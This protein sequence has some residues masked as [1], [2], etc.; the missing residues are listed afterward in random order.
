MYR[1]LSS[2]QQEAQ[3]PAKGKQHTYIN[4][5]S[6]TSKLTSQEAVRVEEHTHTQIKSK[7][8]LSRSQQ[9]AQAPAKGKRLA[10]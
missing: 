2:S 5:E 3:A 7:G 6:H 1:R 4:K 9:E 10:F 8:R